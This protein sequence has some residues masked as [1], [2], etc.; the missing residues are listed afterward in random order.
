MAKNNQHDQLD[1]SNLVQRRTALKAL[2]VAGTGLLSLS[3]VSMLHA[4]DKKKL[5]YMTPFGFQLSFSPVLYTA[6]AGLFNK[7]GIEV[8]VV[9]GR[10]AAQS[11]QMVAAGQVPGGRTGGA[12]YMTSRINN[13]AP[14]IAI[15]TIAQQSPFQLISAKN[16]PITKPAEMAGKTIGI[17]SL[18]GSMEGTVDLMLMRAGVDKKSVTLQRVPDN[19]AS[20]GL[21]DAGRIDGFFGN[22][23]TATRLLVQNH[24]VATLKVDDGFPGQVYIVDEKTLDENRA[25]YISFLRAVHNGIREIA[26]MDDAGLEK[27]IDLIAGKYEISGLND[28]KV[29]IADLRN[30]SAL[31]LTRGVDQALKNNEQQWAEA[32]DLLL[33]A[34][35]IKAKPTKPVY[36]NELWEASR[37]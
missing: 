7:E 13:D 29:A 30:N 22:T 25:L 24:P 17:A 37:G 32:Q 19:P 33:K 4:Q 31:W 34:K 1:Q 3:G 15:A 5:V 11:I 26:A 27:A 2:A 10:G 6:A 16:K 21:I 8:D 14:I 28:K 36:T 20:L 12:N 23:S 18:G 9:G 35:L